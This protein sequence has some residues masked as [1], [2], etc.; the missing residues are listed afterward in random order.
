[1]KL[2]FLCNVCLIVHAAASKDACNG[3]SCPDKD[4]C[5]GLSCPDE[6]PSTDL[7]LLQTHIAVQS[8]QPECKLPNN[9]WW[10]TAVLG[11]KTF[12]MAVYPVE[13]IVSSAICSGGY[14][15]INQYDII[16]LGQPGHALD[17]G[18]NVGFYSLALAAFGW[19]VSSFEPS[20]NNVALMQASMCRNPELAKM[21]TLHNVGLGAAD[22]HCIY[23]SHNSN[24]GDCETRCGMAAI[25]WVDTENERK[26]GEMVVRRLDDIL[27]EENVEQIDYVKM[28]VEG[29]E[30]N[31]MAGGQSLLQKYK[32]RFIQT[33]VWPT[34]Q[35]CQPEAYLASFDK[36]GYTVS[37]NRECTDVNLSMPEKISD[38][39]MCREA[40]SKLFAT[41][42]SLKKAE[43]SILLY[44]RA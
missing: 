25:N 19:K 27:A 13:D 14:W 9:A 11:D 30:C 31:V 1:M 39:Y 7:S 41:R 24:L 36:A 42:P 4:A 40:T 8:T 38:R 23:T 6:D 34:M 3:L 20:E 5:N 37:S 2:T 16:N 26:R 29:F 12:E 18:A 32:P 17:I 35:G 22:N 44:K 10:C 43:R 15:E 21:I 33:E 28:D